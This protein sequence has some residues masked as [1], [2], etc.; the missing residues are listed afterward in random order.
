MGSPRQRLRREERGG[1][2][3]PSGGLWTRELM[4]PKMIFDNMI[5][6]FNRADTLAA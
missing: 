1:K 5:F 6:G 4:V 2:V 3:L